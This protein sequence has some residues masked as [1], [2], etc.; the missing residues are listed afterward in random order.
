[1]NLDVLNRNP[2]FYDYPEGRDEEKERAVR[3]ILEL[4][5]GV[6]R[7]TAECILRDA[8]QYL[9]NLCFIDMKNEVLERKKPDKKPAPWL[10]PDVPEPKKPFTEKIVDAVKGK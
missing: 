8:I 10:T 4:L 7:F 9:D 2:F 3:Q 1:M 5:D 6:N